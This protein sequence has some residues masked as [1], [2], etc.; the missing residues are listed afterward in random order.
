LRTA[1]RSALNTDKANLVE[2][3]LD[4]KM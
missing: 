4:S 1:L 2:V 3:C